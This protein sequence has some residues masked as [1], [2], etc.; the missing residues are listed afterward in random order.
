MWPKRK[1]VSGLPLR[2]TVIL[3]MGDR[4]WCGILSG[5][6][7]DAFVLSHAVTLPD[8]TPCVGDIVIPR[9]ES[10]WFQADVPDELLAAI[11]GRRATPRARIRAVAS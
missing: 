1:P 8:R 4:S 10:V 11:D 5:V 9:E 6:F 2:H 3:N 7:H